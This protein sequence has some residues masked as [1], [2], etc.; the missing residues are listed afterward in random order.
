VSA[1]ESSWVWSPEVLVPVTPRRAGLFAGMDR[2]GRLQP[3]LGGE[4]DPNI[5]ETF[6]WME[7]TTETPRINQIEEWE[8]YI[9][10]NNAVSSASVRVQRPRPCIIHGL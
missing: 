5:V 10:S 4:K 6:T 1:T 9:F 2:Y 8:I 7:P 3:L